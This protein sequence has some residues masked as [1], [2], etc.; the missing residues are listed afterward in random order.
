VGQEIS[1]S[2]QI[3]AC[4]H[5][6][7]EGSVDATLANGQTIEITDGG[8]FTGVAVVDTAEIAGCFCGKLY[9]RQRLTIRAGG[10]I[11][12][13]IR[14]AELVIEAGGKIEGDVA[15]ITEETLVAAITALDSQTGQSAPAPAPEPPTSPA[16]SNAP[17]Q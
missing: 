13:S 6:V 9:V 8:L 17:H 4:E 11:E 2:G 15:D 1:L 12:G 10:R 16:V 7:V 14:C 3:T 5:L